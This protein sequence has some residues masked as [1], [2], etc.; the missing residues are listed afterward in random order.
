MRNIVVS[1]QLTLITALELILQYHHNVFNTR[2]DVALALAFQQELHRVLSCAE[3]A[4]Q[5][6]QQRS[7]Y[8]VWLEYSN[9]VECEECAQYTN[10]GT[11][12]CTQSTLQTHLHMREPNSD[13]TVIENWDWKTTR[14]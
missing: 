5:Q 14:F 7:K 4:R 12:Q 6:Q 1:N 13:G 9:V 8:M 3:Q 11:H 10:A 2:C